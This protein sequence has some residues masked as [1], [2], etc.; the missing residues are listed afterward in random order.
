MS[1]PSARAG[2]RPSS[3]AGRL[4]RC[5]AVVALASGLTGFACVKITE[6][7]AI[8]TIGLDHAQRP[9]VPQPALPE[10]LVVVNGQPDGPGA[11]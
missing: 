5:A 8:L 2:T 6:D 11:D 4:A 9:T 7:P 1:S 10:F 3:S